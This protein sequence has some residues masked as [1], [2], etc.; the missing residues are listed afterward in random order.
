M[1]SP[2]TYIL[3]D[4]NSFMLHQINIQMARAIETKMLIY[5]LNIIMVFGVI[6][7]HH[8]FWFL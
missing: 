4:S 3:I 5:F 8:K 1:I 2:R 6:V 7:A